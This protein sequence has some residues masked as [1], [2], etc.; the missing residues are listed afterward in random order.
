[1]Q[2]VTDDA[3]PIAEEQTPE[4]T[5]PTG[6]LE[7]EG[8]GGGAGKR[9]DGLRQPRDQGGRADDRGGGLRGRNQESDPKE[10]IREG[11]NRRK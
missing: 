10:M 8:G 4:G 7:E 3:G 5:Q 1:M 2:R 6:E 11:M 9:R